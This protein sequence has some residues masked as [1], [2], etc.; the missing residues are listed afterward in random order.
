LAEQVPWAES[1]AEWK[2]A[3]RPRP[4]WWDVLRYA[5]GCKKMPLA[6]EEITEDVLGQKQREQRARWK[7]QGRTVHGHPRKVDSPRSPYYKGRKPR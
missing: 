4:D 6:M 1:R 2:A 3:G 7:A 5:P